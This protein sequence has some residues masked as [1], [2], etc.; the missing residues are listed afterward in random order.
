VRLSEPARVV[1]PAALQDLAG[2]PIPNPEP[3]PEPPLP[4]PDPDPSPA[5]EDS[6]PIAP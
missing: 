2:S 6:A 4:G 5:P 1:L 3:D